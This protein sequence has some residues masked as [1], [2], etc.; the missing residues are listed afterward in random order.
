[1]TSKASK[2]RHPSAK[3]EY[4]GYLVWENGKSSPAVPMNGS[5]RYGYL[6]TDIDDLDGEG[7][8]SIVF[9]D[10]ED[11]DDPDYLV[12]ERFIRLG[13]AVWVENRADAMYVPR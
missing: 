13:S 9:C 8:V 1:M 10:D 2:K 3:R 7:P 5:H 12:R 6:A 4:F 11:W